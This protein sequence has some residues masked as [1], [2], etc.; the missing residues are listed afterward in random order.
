[1]GI[2]AAGKLVDAPALPLYIRIALWAPSIANYKTNAVLLTMEIVKRK[3]PMADKSGLSKALNKLV[4]MGLLRREGR[5]SY[6]TLNPDYAWMGSAK[7]HQ[8]AV[9]E[10][11]AWERAEKRKEAGIVEVAEPESD[12]DPDP[13][14]LDEES[15]DE[16]AE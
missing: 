5:F 14:P 8:S 7:D 10:W 4:G 6:F 16:A 1:M 15:A 9:Q 2:M 13:D 12:P 3:F 11:R